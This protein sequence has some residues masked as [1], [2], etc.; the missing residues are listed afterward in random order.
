MLATR[1]RSGVTSPRPSGCTRFERNTTNTRDAGSIQ[2]DVPVKPVWPNEPSGRNSPR[3]D[4]Y[5]E[6]TS[7]P[8]P[9][10]LASPAGE[11]GAV[12]RSTA[13]GE[14]TRAVPTAPPSS[15]MRQ[16]IA[17]SLAVLKRP[18]CP[19]T[20]PMRRAVGS[21]TTPR[22]V[23]GCVGA[24]RPWS[25]RG[26]LNVVSR[27]PSGWKT[28]SRTNDVELHLR[29]A[30]DDFAEHEVVDVAVDESPAGRGERNLFGAEPDRRVVALPGIGEVDVGPQAR[31]VRHQ[32]A[33]GDA[34]LAVL[35]ELRHEFRHRIDQANLVPPRA[36]S[37]RRSSSRR[38]S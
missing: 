21:C 37:S 22:S 20:P 34:V 26:G 6:S 13:S 14:S 4:E 28:R 35:P 19:A 27:M 30:L 2:S 8:R 5:D 32:V 1:A 9:R 3:F 25:A 10:M 15:S 18:A 29:D 36:G 24:M 33:N 7:Q 31:H 17:R 11:A 23:A 38:P 16:K 12:M